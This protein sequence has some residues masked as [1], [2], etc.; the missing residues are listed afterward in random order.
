MSGNAQQEAAGQ[1]SRTNAQLATELWNSSKGPLSEILGMLNQGISGGPNAIPENISRQF[2]AARTEANTGYDSAIRTNRELAAA[3]ARTSGQPFSTGELD[4]AIAQGTFALNQQRDAAMRNLQ[5]QE[6][7][8]GMQQYNQ[9]LN[10][11]GMGANTAIGMGQGMGQAQLGA[12]GQMSQGGGWGGV[13]GGAAS[14]AAMGST[15]APGWGTAIGA[16]LGGVMGGLG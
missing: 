15:F 3:R 16:V 12:I 13:L 10:L 9:Y 4:A 14:G 11:M 8:A 5:F 7:Q 1:A 6:A 2:D